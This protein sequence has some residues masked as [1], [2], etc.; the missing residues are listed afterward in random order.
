MRLSAPSA[1]VFLLSLAF[2]IIA[3]LKYY[4]VG[5]PQVPISIMWCFAIAY[6]ILFIGVVS[7]GL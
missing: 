1:I 6:A 2:A 5:I 3:I 4:G 7:R